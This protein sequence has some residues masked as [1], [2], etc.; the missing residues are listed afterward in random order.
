MTESSQGLGFSVD[1]ESGDLCVS[2]DPASGAALPDVTSIQTRLVASGCGDYFIDDAALISFVRSCAEAEQLIEQVIGQ[3]RDGEFMLT[4]S[5]DL[6]SA[7]LTLISPQGG[8]SAGSA[9]IDALYQQRITFGIRHA[10]LGAAVNAGHCEHLLIAQGV[11]PQ[12]GVATVF[13]PVFEEIAADEAVADE[14]AVIRFADISRLLLV[15]PN[16]ALMRRQPPVPGKSG[17][18]IHNE[19]VMPRA[20]SDE[21]FFLDLQGAAPDPADPDLLVATLAGQPVVVACGVKVNPVIDVANVDF[22]TGSINFEGTL[23]VTGDIRSGMRVN[24]TGDVIVRGTIEAAEIR[25]GGNVS[26]KGG[27]IGRGEGRMG[28]ANALPSDTARIHCGGTLQ[29][30]FAEN[31]HVESGDS[32]LID[33]EATHCELIATK[34]IVIGKGGPRGG[35]LVGGTAQATEQIECNVMGSVTGTRTR[36]QVG[37]DPYLDEIMLTK[38]RQLQQKGD[39]LE[40]VILLQ[41]YLQQNPQRNKEGLGEKTDNTQVQLQDEIEVLNDELVRL[42]EQQ[43]TVDQARIVVRKAL[44]FGTEIRI[45]RQVIQVADDMGAATAK[46]QD[47]EIVIDH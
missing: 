10:A 19:V 36:V 13:Q 11:P 2:Y 42:E 31:A 18:N 17:T 6:M 15:H 22:E 34:R 28:A 7:Y 12:E 27:I 21:S 4:V 16:D 44:Y 33:R 32:I 38:R 41:R 25:A 40:R 26:V 8:K 35:Y 30:H 46:L 37:L 3:R 5:D 45:G 20:I 24:V 43:A 23:N 47:G 9:V 29:A 39:D 1:D 14:N